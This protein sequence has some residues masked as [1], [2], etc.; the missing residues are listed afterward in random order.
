MWEWEG[1]QFGGVV[2]EGVPGESHISTEAWVKGESEPGRD[3]EIGLSKLKEHQGQWAMVELIT[4]CLKD[5]L[6]HSETG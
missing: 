1:V 4:A 3:T 5:W 6:E 2:K